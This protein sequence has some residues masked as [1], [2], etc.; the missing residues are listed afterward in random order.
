MTEKVAEL[1]TNNSKPALESENVM[2]D[3]ATN[4][5]ALQ[6]RIAQLVSSDPL[7]SRIQGRLEILRGIREIIEA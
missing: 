6:E 2:N 5:N 3:I 4:E 7:A 1:P